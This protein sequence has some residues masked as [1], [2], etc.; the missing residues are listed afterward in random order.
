M[1]TL[2]DDYSLVAWAIVIRA[3]IGLGRGLDL[4]ITAEGV[5]TEAQREFLIHE[6]CQEI[7]GYLIGRPQPI[8]EYSGIV[9]RPPSPQAALA[10]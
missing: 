6:S 9:G 10:S 4:P 5:E 2:Q 1:F 8:G 7:Q 3:V